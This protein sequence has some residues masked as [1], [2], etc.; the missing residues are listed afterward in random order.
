MQH[1]LGID[2]GG[3]KTVCLLADEQGAVLAEARAPGANLASAGE[4]EVE[5][6]LRRAMTDA[7]GNRDIR[8][9]AICLGVA[10]VDRSD[11]AAIVRGIVRR[12]GYDV[13][14]LV[15]NDALLALVAGAG[16]APGI[17]IIAGTG[18]MAYGRNARGRAARA[19]GWGYVMSDEGSGYWIGRRALQA[20]MRASDLRGPATQLT[21]RMLRHFGIGTARDLVQVVYYG[22]LRQPGVAALAAD[23]GIAAADGDAV[24]RR[25][26]GDAADELMIAVRAVV[27][28]LDMANEPFTAVLAGGLFQAVP[29]LAGQLDARLVETTPSARVSRLSAEPA[30]GAVRLALDELSGGARIPAYE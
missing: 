1:V 16:R 15:V 7:L 20:V 10:G 27:T 21:D 3:T 28:R 2:A 23:V 14:T 22:S 18:S 26:L 29:W 6:V 11:H 9:A 30:T 5:S 13:P 4:R 8:P 17:V 12:I 19:G 24:A 25:I